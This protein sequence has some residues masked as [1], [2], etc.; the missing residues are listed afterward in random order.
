MCLHG[1]F[2]ENKMSECQEIPSYLWDFNNK[3]KAF[4]LLRLEWLHFNTRTGGLG[5]NLLYFNKFLVWFCLDVT[6]L[7]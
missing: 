5:L 3:F 1:K 7:M 4:F 2:I 6:S